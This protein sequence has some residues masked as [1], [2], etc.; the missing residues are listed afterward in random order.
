M[1]FTKGGEMKPIKKDWCNV[2]YAENQP[3]YTPLPA[4]KSATGE[5]TTC[6]KLSWKERI[7]ALFIGEM[8]LKVL[9]FNQP[10]QPLLPWF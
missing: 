9:T 4:F 2:I 3:E 1:A 6:W 7:K 5:I 10:L 8:Q